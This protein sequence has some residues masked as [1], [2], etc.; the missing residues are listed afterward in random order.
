MDD[1]RK[2]LGGR[3]I[4]RLTMAVILGKPGIFDAK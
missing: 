3:R 1:A 2:L 4:V